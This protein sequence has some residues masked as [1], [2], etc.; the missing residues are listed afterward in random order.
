[1]AG[2][3]LLKRHLDVAPLLLGSPAADRYGKK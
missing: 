3:G 1:M 2:A